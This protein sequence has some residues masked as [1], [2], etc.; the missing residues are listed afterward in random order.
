MDFIT[1]NLNM[2][3]FSMRCFVFLS[4]TYDVMLNKK[5]S[6][7]SI[8]LINKIAHAVV[9]EANLNCRRAI[10]VSSYGTYM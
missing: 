10:I 7:C 6:F 2:S 9:P 1:V 3:V 5:K 8:W 4:S